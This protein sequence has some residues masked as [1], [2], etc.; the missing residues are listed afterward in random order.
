MIEMRVLIAAG[1]GSSEAARGRLRLAAPGQA[2]ADLNAGSCEQLRTAPRLSQ[3]LVSVNQAHGESYARR[4]V[5]SRRH[6]P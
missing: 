2:A 6:A 3:G 5:M 1:A 4:A